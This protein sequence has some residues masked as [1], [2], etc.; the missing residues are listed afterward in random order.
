MIPCAD[1]QF[2]GE[3]IGGVKYTGAGKMGDFRRI[4]PF[5]TETMRDRPMVRPYYAVASIPPHLIPHAFLPTLPSVMRT[6]FSFPLLSFSLPLPFPH[7]HSLPLLN[8]STWIQPRKNLANL[9]VH[10]C[11]LMCIVYAENNH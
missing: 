6:A 2:Q 8:L 9:N 5:I 3:S 10:T 4:L 11:I 7:S 1:A